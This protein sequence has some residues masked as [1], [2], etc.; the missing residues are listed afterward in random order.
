MMKTLPEIQ[1]ELAQKYYGVDFSALCCER[2]KIIRDFALQTYNEE[3]EK[4]QSEVA[5]TP[6]EIQTLEKTQ[7]SD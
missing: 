3:K 6:N 1:N 7:N 2:F 4:N 5:K